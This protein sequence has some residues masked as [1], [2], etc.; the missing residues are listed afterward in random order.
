MSVQVPFI[1]KNIAIVSYEQHKRVPKCIILKLFN[2]KAMKA[3]L[4]SNKPS[5]LR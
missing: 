4:S 3:G 2:V 1:V 5:R